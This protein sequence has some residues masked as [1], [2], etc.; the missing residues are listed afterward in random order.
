[1]KILLTGANGYIGRR[2][3]PILLDMSHEVICCVRDRDRFISPDNRKDKIQVIEVDFLSSDLFNVLPKDID[4]AYYLIHSMSSNTR[5][6]NIKENQ[7]AYNFKEYVHQTNARHVIYLSGITNES[8]LSPHLAS[9][10]NVEEIL[11]QSRCNLTVLRAGIIIGSGSASFEIIRDLV[12]KLPFMV[13]PRWINT[14]CQ[15]IAIR[16]V[17]EYLV[18]VLNHPLCTNK[19]FDIG[20]P[21]ILTYKEMLLGYA[22]VR[23][24]KR[25]ILTIPVLSPRISSYWLYFITSTSYK[26]ATNLVDSMKVNVVCK[27]QELENTLNIHPIGYK[28]AVLRTLGKIAQQEIISSW[29]DSYSSSEFSYDKRINMIPPQFGC[30]KDQRTHEVTISKQQVLDNIWSIGGERGWYY[31]SWIWKLRGFLDKIMGG[32]GLN[33]GRRH[34]TQIV[35]GDAIDFW[36]VLYSNRKEGRLLLYAEMILPGEAWLEF[37]LEDKKIK[38]ILKQTATFRP[39][40]LWGRVYWYLSKPLHIIIF[41]GMLRKICCSVNNRISP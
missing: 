35:E 4:A 10:K 39:K 2:L 3:L 9:R 17:L 12:E 5:N 6:F 18:G 30:L 26:L 25:Y 38:T 19:T 22:K 14:K 29:K 33:R 40:G 23:N 13:A 11:K 37:S 21:D 8:E 41:Q 16:N 31:A 1:M 24:L 28:K 32:V 27:E 36:R 34:P 20:G 15:P 7:T